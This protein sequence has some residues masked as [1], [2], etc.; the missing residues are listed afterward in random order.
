MYTAA[1]HQD[2]QFYSL[3]YSDGAQLNV[4]EDKGMKHTV[5]VQLKIK[6]GIKA[7]SIFLVTHNPPNTQN[8]QTSTD[9]NSRRSFT[10]D[11]ILFK[12]GSY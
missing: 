7:Y 10:V 9:L 4:R 11:R 8:F 1:F 12:C 3:V 2:K 6:E 5:Q